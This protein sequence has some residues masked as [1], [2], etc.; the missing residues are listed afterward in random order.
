MLSAF[1]C[2]SGGEGKD[3]STSAP[4]S[5]GEETTAPEETDGLPEKDMD[6]FE[7]KIVH[8]DGNWL[9]WALTKLDAE[10]ET[11]D[12]LNDAIYKRNR[13]M[14]ERFNCEINVT[15]KE[16][17]NAGDI[18]SEIM[19]GD[20]NYDVWFMYDNWTLGAVEYLLPWE[21]LPYIN[22]DREWW[23]PSATEV[24]NLEGKTY[25]AASNYS[26]S[27]LSRASGFAFNKD[28][29]NKM[30]LSENIYDL[31]REGNWTIDVMYDTAKDA[32]ID[33]DG[34]SSMNENDQ[35]GISGSWKE[36][37]WRFLS[38]SDVRFISKDSNSDPVFEL[39]KNETAINK[40]LKIFDLF[41]EK[42]I[43]YNPQTRDVHRVLES[44]E[45]FADGRLLFKTV[46]F[47]DLESLRTCDIDIGIL[48]CPKYDEN[49]EN[50]YAPYFGAEIS[51]LLKTLP[52]ER[53][54]NVGML[55]EA[56]AYDS[57]ANILPEYKEVLLKTK[58]ARDNE[59]EEMI[60]IIINS[61]SFDFGI[62]AWQNEV[63]V[64][65]VQRIYV[66]NDP[67][68]AS[69]QKSVDAQIAK[70]VEKLGK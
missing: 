56:L 24:F 48:P 41:T 68:V 22:L 51:V 13:N 32:Y 35:Y 54:E 42:G 34:D 50:Y 40:M 61:I 31:A 10:S 2:G 69:M 4:D 17:I 45:I 7:L 23:N 3:S 49:Q 21:E 39:P 11:G 65:I 18:Q 6:K 53:K 33:L 16:T 29:Y 8:F 14:E 47:F 58:L 5:T 62:N 46:N 59:S 43:C 57:N 37:F 9:S 60:D 44:E 20:S 36:T 63:G 28:I 12:R 66:K 38:G 19:A 64:P 1:S 52:E 55:L 26:L 67:N 70:L 25:A 27:V 15:G 30:N